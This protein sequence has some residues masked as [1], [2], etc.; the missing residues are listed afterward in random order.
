MDAAIRRRDDD[1]RLLVNPAKAR[2]PQDRAAPIRQND[3]V[4]RR[5]KVAGDEL[6]AVSI[7]LRHDAVDQ[8]ADETRDAAQVCD[9]GDEKPVGVRVVV[10]QVDDDLPGG[11]GVLSRMT[12]E[13]GGA[14]QVREAQ[15]PA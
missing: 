6:H 10:A 12:D 15:F 4:L 3:D 13:D 2:R 9:I 1:A 5:V 7:R 14:F 8:A 11:A